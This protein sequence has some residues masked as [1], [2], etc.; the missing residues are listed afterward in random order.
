MKK[1][2]IVMNLSLIFLTLV[3]IILFLPLWIHP[4]SQ[5]LSPSFFIVEICTL[6]ISYISYRIHHKN[7]VA[8]KALINRKKTILA[9]WTY[10]PNTSDTI[11][12]AILA[13]KFSSF[14]T[15]ILACIVGILLG[16]GFSLVHMSVFYIVSKIIYVLSFLSFIV[17][18]LT[19]IK[20][21]SKKLSTTS[22]AIIGEDSF[23]FLDRLY[24]MQ[25]S[26]YILSEVRLTPGKE[27]CLSFI[28]GFCG[29]SIKSSYTIN[30][31]IPSGNLEIAEYICNHY[32]N[33]I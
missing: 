2:W 1:E 28:Y 19:L 25:K 11:Q 24:P 32:E 29:N 16:V 30:I 22:L 15:L 23:Y 5:H 10:A 17:G 4:L 20:Y 31:P 8:I 13:E 9:Y 18:Y 6:S 3:V 21:Y 27:D 33:I 14:Y 26:M 12:E 7:Y